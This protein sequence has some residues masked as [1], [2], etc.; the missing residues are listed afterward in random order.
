[1]KKGDLVYYI[2]FILDHKFRWFNYEKKK[3]KCMQV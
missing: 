3:I 2:Q 1:M